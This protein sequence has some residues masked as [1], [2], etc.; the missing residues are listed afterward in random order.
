MQKLFILVVIFV[1]ACTAKIANN[2]IS[3]QPALTESDFVLVLQQSD[4]F[5]N[6][7]IKVGSIQS[8]D[9][10]FSVN[11]S[12]NEVIE[13]LRTIARANGAN[14]IKI[15]KRVPPDTKSTCER[16]YADIYRVPDFKKHEL[17]IDWS[18]NR[19]LS[20]E[21]FKGTAPNV[22]SKVWFSA[23][24]DCNILLESNTF[25]L[26]KKPKFFTQ[27][28]F[29]TFSSWVN[30][31]KKSDSLLVHEQY[32]FNIAEVYRRKLQKLLDKSNFS[33]SKAE[34]DAKRIMRQISKQYHNE[35]A[36]YDEETKHGVN[37][38][39]QREWERRIDSIISIK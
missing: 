18:E 25:G 37:R 9:N 20:W 4:H 21:D 19:K 38:E 11:C 33:F 31:S 15:S 10:G 24:S 26:F 3:K 16:I 12:Y 28:K 5:I 23:G 32:H 2:I 13:S 22:S 1:S 29:Y 6:D 39:K 27:A 14:V 17:E 34:N 8:V 35:Q 7:G 30:G 36:V